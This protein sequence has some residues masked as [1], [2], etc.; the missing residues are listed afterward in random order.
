MLAARS[1]GNMDE[2]QF[3]ALLQANLPHRTINAA[4]VRAWEEKPPP[5]TGDVVMVAMGLLG[6]DLAVQLEE[7]IGLGPGEGAG[8]APSPAGNDAS[9]LALIV[10]RHSQRCGAAPPA[11]PISTPEHQAFRLS[12]QF[13]KTVVDPSC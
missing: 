2:A 4:M 13:E 1:R 10:T 11:P 12:L 9:G 8:S 3:A 5:P 6:L 7:Q